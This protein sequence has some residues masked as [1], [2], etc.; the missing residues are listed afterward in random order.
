MSTNK[1][2]MRGYQSVGS[3]GGMSLGENVRKFRQEKGWSQDELARRIG[4]RQ[5]TINAIE[6]GGRTKYLAEL[7]RVFGKTVD[8]LDPP[9][10]GTV[11]LAPPSLY[12]VRD[13]PVYASAEGG[14]GEVIRSTDPIDWVPR[15]APAQTPEAYC[16]LI[17]GESMYPEFRPG[18]SAIVNPKLPIIGGEVYVFYRE[19]QGEARATIK[20]LRRQSAEVWQ[21]LQH[22][23]PAGQ[24]PEFNL[25]RREWQWAHRVIGKYSRQ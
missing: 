12:G 24:K 21:V 25:P 16:I 1:L 9:A 7:A 13:F 19:L 23:P 4:V 8:E 14:P 17:S 22:N 18:D 11:P 6:Q 5:G 10:A 2:L 15:P 20:Q 3:L